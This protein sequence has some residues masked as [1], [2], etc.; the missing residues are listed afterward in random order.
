MKFTLSSLFIP[1][2]AFQA[3][4][5]AMAEPAI[6][7]TNSTAALD[8]FA[9][10]GVIGWSEPV[11][12]EIYH[13]CNSTTARMINAGLKDSLE[14]SSYAK[15]R[16]LEY[17]SEDEIYQRWFGNGSIFTVVGVLDWLVESNKDSLLYRCDDIDGQCAEHS[18]Y[19]GYYR[20]D[21]S[22][23]TVICDLFY[24]SKK[25]L[26]NMCYLG[27]LTDVHPKTYA[28]IDLLHRYLHIP[29]MSDDG[30]IGE[31]VDELE[32][33]L[34]YAQHNSSYAVR[35]VDSYLYYIADAY[36]IGVVPGGCLGD[37]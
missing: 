11:F 37:I 22:G 9:F 8:E 14:V 21:I 25:P 12:A 1:F 10:S 34:G 26:Y 23:E 7:E 36:S 2:V 16:L 32:D 31:Y 24:T 17:G 30:Y 18:N 15:K 3:T 35:N 5:F 6:Y 19:P 33:I 13:T 4:K 20:G 27:T 29:L 28:G